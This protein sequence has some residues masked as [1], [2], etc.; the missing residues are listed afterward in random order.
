MARSANA[1]HGPIADAPAE[2]VISHREVLGVVDAPRVP[3]R[4]GAAAEHEDIVPLRASIDAALSALSGGA[5]HNGPLVLAL[6]W[7]ALNRG[8]L[9]EIVRTGSASP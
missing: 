5:I 3:T 7:L 6:Q 2:S 1:V 4:A 9:A 8:R